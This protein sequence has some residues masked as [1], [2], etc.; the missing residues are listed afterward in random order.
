M[1]TT[2]IETGIGGC[3]TEVGHCVT[4][5][6]VVVLLDV[7]CTVDNSK[8]I[9][10]RADGP[11]RSF[12]ASRGW[13]YD[14]K[15]R[16]NITNTANPIIRPHRQKDKS[17]ST[18][19]FSHFLLSNRPHYPT[20]RVINMDETPLPFLPRG[21]LYRLKVTRQQSIQVLTCKHAQSHNFAFYMDEL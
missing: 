18:N 9:A 3:G 10:A 17:Y 21:M 6:D 13:T 7:S 11:L 16:H 8:P 2:G 4:G 15:K 20:D 1:Q 14:F 5:T 19:L 12:H